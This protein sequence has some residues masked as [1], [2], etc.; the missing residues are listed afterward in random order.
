MPEIAK[1]AA[2]TFCWW[3][4]ATPDLEAAWRFYHGLFRWEKR[5]AP[6]GAGRVYRIC[7]LEGQ[8]VG[9]MYQLDSEPSERKTPA[10]WLPYL[11]VNS[12]DETAERIRNAGGAVVT[13]PFDVM[14][15]GRMALAADPEAAR[16]ALWEPKAHAG[17]GLIRE[18]GTVAWSELTA[19]DVTR[20]RAFYSELFGWNVESR[21]MG[22]TGEYDMVRIA[23][24]DAFA[25]ILQQPPWGKHQQ[26]TWWTYFRVADCDETA[27]AVRSA[28]GIIGVGPF[29][30]PEAGRIAIAADPGGA[31]FAII[32]VASGQ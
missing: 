2:G 27:A 25:G 4:L 10:A 3:E 28:G 31:G 6:I 14:E 8:D 21:P 20:A 7:V 18:I 23:G 13:P 5:D 9:A 17:A 24:Q 16:F 22:P 12:A 29:D 1:H 32:Q 26:P 30:V 19:R 15:S 11:A